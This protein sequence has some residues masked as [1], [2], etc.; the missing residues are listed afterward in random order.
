MLDARL[1]RMR[2]S[3]ALVLGRERGMRVGWAR[4]RVRRSGIEG[5]ERVVRMSM[6]GVMGVGGIGDFEWA[7]VVW[8]CG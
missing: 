4:A 3:M 8:V 1:M 2:A 5:G 7:W 6:G